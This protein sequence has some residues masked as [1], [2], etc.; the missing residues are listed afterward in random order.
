MSHIPNCRIIHLCCSEF[1]Y[2]WT[3]FDTTVCQ[4]SDFNINV[5]L[6]NIL[7]C[8]SRAQVPLAVLKRSKVVFVVVK[9]YLIY[10]AV[11]HRSVKK[12]L[13]P[14]LG[15]RPQF[16]YV[17]RRYI[18]SQL[19]VEDKFCKLLKIIGLWLILFMGTE[20]DFLNKSSNFLCFCRAN[21]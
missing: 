14:T 3:K 20:F 2:S 15:G 12:C 1:F 21:R 10:M 19:Q 8:I 5:V 4:I 18:S 17:I 6:I 9:M 13:W 11:H 7:W 16:F